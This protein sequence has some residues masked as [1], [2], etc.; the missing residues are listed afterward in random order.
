MSQQELPDLQNTLL[1]QILL[2]HEAYH[3]TEGQLQHL[4]QITTLNTTMSSRLQT[5]FTVKE[6]DIVSCCVHVK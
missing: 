6:M 5:Y 4:K 2:L 3:K 1:Q